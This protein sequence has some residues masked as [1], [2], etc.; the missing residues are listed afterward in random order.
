VGSDN[1]STV[2]L[3]E[4]D[5]RAGGPAIQAVRWLSAGMPSLY[6]RLD[7]NRLTLGRGPEADV[8]LDA[9]G[10]SRLHA[11]IRRQGPVYVLSDEAS[12]NGT[13][14]NGTAVQ[15]C[16]LSAG[17][18][19]RLG[20]VLGVVVRLPAETDLEAPDDAELVPGLVCGPGLRQEL[21]SL[22]R[23][24]PSDLPVVIVGETGTG[25]ECVARAIHVRSGRPGEF[26]AINCAAVPAAL[27]EA[28]LF[29][30][31]KGA[32][33]GA[34]QGGLGHFRAA[35][36][37]TLFLD[38]LADLP[39][40]VQAK[41]LR[42]LQE[43]KVMALGGTRTENVN[44]RVLAAVQAPLE[45]LVAAGRVREDLAMRLSGLTLR[46]PPLRERR[47]DVA[48]T[49][50]YFLK[51]HSG[52]RAPAVEPR[53]LEAL[54]LHEW[55]GNVRELE[56]TAKRLLLL[57]GHEPAL[58]RSMLPELARNAVKS[59]AT[60]PSHAPNRTKS[61]HDSARLAAELRANGGNLARASEAVGISRQR[62]YRLLS[63]RTVS[64]FIAET[65]ADGTGD[66]DDRSNPG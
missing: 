66:D 59:A 51:A 8:R 49:F 38:E 11:E 19:L 43:H 26:H 23:A 13:F 52:G 63:G 65:G 48:I 2:R 15:H 21:T 61:E 3:E 47:V 36:R 14:V 31:R 25:K 44:V 29:G 10:V 20:E 41:L 16:A 46:L 22:E 58:R 17:D 53:L 37:G 30:H 18:V 27:A 50:S 33:T 9:A 6:T 55:P 62:A 12:T 28:E 56:L 4:T 45:G 34:E 40:G 54:M 42:V 39:L 24:A 7:R 57:H 64:E 5:R 1:Q 35:D 60:R 32:F